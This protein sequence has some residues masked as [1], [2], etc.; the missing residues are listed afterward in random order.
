[1]KTAAIRRPENLLAG[2]E[3]V[4]RLTSHFQ[5]RPCRGGRTEA[6]KTGPVERLAR[7]RDRYRLRIREQHPELRMNGTQPAA[8][9][10]FT[11]IGPDLYLIA[12]G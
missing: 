7:Y 5:A 12:A 4:D 6:C 3:A 10:T 1:M 8:G 2:H 11:T 9:F